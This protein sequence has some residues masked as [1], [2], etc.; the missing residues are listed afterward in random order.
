MA[1]HQIPFQDANQMAGF[2]YHHAD[3]SLYEWHITQQR[4]GQS[5]SCIRNTLPMA[6]AV[7]IGVL[8]IS[9]FHLIL[10]SLQIV[11][12]AIFPFL[13]IETTGMCFLLSDT[14]TTCTHKQKNVY[15]P[16]RGRKMCSSTRLLSRQVNRQR[17]NTPNRSDAQLSGMTNMAM[18]YSCSLTTSSCLLPQSRNS[19][20]QDG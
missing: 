4:K 7:A 2:I 15:C 12:I 1:T 13:T 17:K 6:N 3:M 9:P 11:A 19:T 18:W 5:S 14:G 10:Q 16:K 8:W 20:R